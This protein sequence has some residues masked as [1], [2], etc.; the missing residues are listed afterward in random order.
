MVLLDTNIYGELVSDKISGNTIAENM[1]GDPAFVVHNFKVIRDELRRAKNILK[2]YDLIVSKNIIPDSTQITKL[3]EEYYEE[4]KKE[5]GSEGKNKN[6]LNDL[7]IVAC[8]S[9]K[10]LNIIFSND[11][12]MTSPLLYNCYKSINLRYNYRTP[13]FYSYSDL[14]KKYS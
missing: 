12:K 10:S 11:K 9:I 14:K 4:F 1:I 8:A 6:F 7:K 13:T 3:A 2:L 5:G